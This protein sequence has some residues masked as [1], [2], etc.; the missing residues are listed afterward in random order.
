MI[1]PG[2]PSGDGG[3]PEGTLKTATVADLGESTKIPSM[4][5]RL[6]TVSGCPPVSSFVGSCSAIHHF[7]G[8]P[9]I[10]T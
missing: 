9:S 8:S 1:S 6:V 2:I 7:V 10:C 3:D 4:G 5:A